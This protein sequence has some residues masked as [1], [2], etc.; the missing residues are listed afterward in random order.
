VRFDN[1]HY[2]KPVR[3]EEIITQSHPLVRFTSWRIRAERSA[4]CAGS[5]S[6]CCRRGSR[7]TNQVHP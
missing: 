6:S 5:K 7:S 1:R 3:G 4:A 2:L